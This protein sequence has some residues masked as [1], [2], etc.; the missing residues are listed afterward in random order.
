MCSI[1]AICR[2]GFATGDIMKS[3]QLLVYKPEEGAIQACDSV[4]VDAFVLRFVTS[5]LASNTHSSRYKTA[6]IP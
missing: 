4:G 6:S 2:P 3:L 1:S 5:D